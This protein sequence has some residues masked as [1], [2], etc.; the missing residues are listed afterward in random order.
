MTQPLG[1][2]ALGEHQNDSFVNNEG[3]SLVV[4]W[5]QMHA[6]TAKGP[7]SISGWGDKIPE[8]MQCGTLILKQQKTEM[9]L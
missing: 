4:Q 8:T 9:R 5:L 2:S 6:F 3:N 7:G 1:F